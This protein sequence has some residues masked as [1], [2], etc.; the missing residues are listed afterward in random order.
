[1]ALSLLELAIVGVSIFLRLDALAL[2]Q[3]I[4]PFAFVGLLALRHCHF[5][6]TM[7]LSL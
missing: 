1:M 7:T 2:W 3:P 5:A 4:L 6:L